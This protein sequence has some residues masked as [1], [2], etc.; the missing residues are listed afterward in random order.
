MNKTKISAFGALGTLGAE[1]DSDE[2]EVGVS[3]NREQ[4]YVQHEAKPEAT[5]STTSSSKSALLNLLPAPKAKTKSLSVFGKGT[6]GSSML[7]PSTLR[8]TP[9][10]AAPKVQPATSSLVSKRKIE[11][12]ESDDDDVTD[13]FGLTVAPEV[14]SFF[15]I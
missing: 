8:K 2:E 1:S 10:A 14:P 12:D 6:G 7:L 13:F 15:F 5:R 11:S 4:A 3:Y 9:A